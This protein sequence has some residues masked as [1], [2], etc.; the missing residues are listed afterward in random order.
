MMTQSL[1]LFVFVDLATAERSRADA[2]EN[3][4]ASSFFTSKERSPERFDHVVFALLGFE[5]FRVD[6][7]HADGGNDRL[8]TL[9]IST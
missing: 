3:A 1:R 9:G 4:S 2:G 6:R 7:V 8:V 5:L